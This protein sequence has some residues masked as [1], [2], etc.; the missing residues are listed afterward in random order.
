MP[1]TLPDGD[2]VPSDGALPGSALD[3]L[4][5]R[6][7][8]F[9]VHVPFCVTRCGYCDFNTYTAT[10][11]RGASREAY[12]DTAITE[13][14]LARRVLGDADLPVQTVFVGGGTPTLLPADDL[15]RILD[16]IDKEFGL[17]AD[18]E[19]T[20]EA[21]PETV[22]AGYLARLREAGFTRMSFGMQSSR[23][24]VL[25]VLDRTHT[26]GRPQQC[27]RWAREAGF[28][29]VNLDLIYGAPGE[30][31]ADWRASLDAALE[32]GPDHVSA[33]A[34]IV[35]EGTRLAAQVRRGEVAAPDDDAMADRYLAAEQALGGQGLRWYEISNWAADE[36]SR[37]RHNLLYW[38]GG[39]WWGI[40]PGAHSH[41]GG[42]RW[43]NVKH[44]AAYAARLTAGTTPAHA[45]EILDAADR[46]FERV[47][48]ELRLAEGCPL[49]L[50]DDAA[51]RGAVAD[52]LLV[53]EAY[54]AGR[55]VLT[56][57]GR[58]L[59]DAVVRDLTP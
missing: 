34:L 36:E 27:V 26:A 38:T 41:V 17:A 24:H 47:M 31:D 44:P 42:T 21:N 39:D 54:D 57:R 10:E 19:V 1:S 18:A 3:G 15:G 7:F 6:P 28:D 2:P 22:D 32:A 51:V 48:L 50:L 55:A 40:G 46:R 33:Y 16:A 29:H 59:A 20:T 5:D 56:L 52:G 35:E 4:G 43:W 23:E 9:Y 53:P 25:A 30:S 45:R 13:I 58:L 49:N 11:L 14:R 8:G 12:A 37:C